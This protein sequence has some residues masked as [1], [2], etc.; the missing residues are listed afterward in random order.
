MIRQ[1]QLR[2]GLLVKLLLVGLRSQSQ[3][4]STILDVAET[5]AAKHDDVTNVTVCFLD[6]LLGLRLARHVDE[7]EL[8][9]GGELLV[10]VRVRVTVR[11]RVRVRVRGG[12]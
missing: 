1:Q 12:G 11:V 2:A 10:R 4:A 9:L 7:R 8:T 5:T 3:E 6:G